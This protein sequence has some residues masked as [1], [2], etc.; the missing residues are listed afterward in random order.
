[1]TD[2]RPDSS[3][4]SAAR[5]LLLVGLGLFTGLLGLMVATSLA[6]RAAPVFEPTPVGVHLMPD[7]AEVL[8]TVDARDETAWRY[9]DLDTGTA[10]APGDSTGWDLAAQRF[11]LRT[12][13]GDLARWYRYGFMTH[14]LEP[15]G[16][17]YDVV[18]D[19]DRTA[20]VEVVSYYCP[21]LQ[22]G[23]LTLRYRLAPRSPPDP[24]ASGEPRPSAT[25]FSAATPP[26]WRRDTRTPPR[27]PH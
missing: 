9:V 4:R 20:T 21:G 26:D 18:T 14:L 27:R 6:R 8:I 7:T 12:A 19:Q 5:T 17:S 25:A 16:V 1:M 13:G 15:A 11:R 22:A 3:A 10:L 23:C 24:G 2:P